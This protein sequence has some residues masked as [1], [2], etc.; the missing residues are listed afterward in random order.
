MSDLL[1]LL[2]AFLYVSIVLAVSEISRRSLRL[3]VDLTRKFVH[4]AVG[5]IAFPLVILFQA[6]QF[7]IIPPLV[8]IVVNY[9]S[10]RRQIFAGME[11]GE[12]GQLGTVYFPISFSILIPLL[13]P[14]PALLVASLMPLT[15]GDAFAALIGQRFGARRFTIL[16]QTRSIEGTSAMFVFSLL[17]V[18][19]TLLFFA[20]PIATSFVFALIVALIA[21]IVEAFSPFGID[22]LTVPLSSAI[23]LVV[24]N[25]VIGK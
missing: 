5:M 13:W 14:Q 25:G 23:V 1:A 16:G 9:V 21:S 18:F 24:L 11:T 2:I 17:A 3:S 12:R 15:W 19:L 20:Q 4:I 7:A 10:Y 22:N 6:W 8:F